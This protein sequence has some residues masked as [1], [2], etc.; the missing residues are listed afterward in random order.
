MSKFINVKIKIPPRQTVRGLQVEDM[1]VDEFDT[2]LDSEREQFC[3]TRCFVC[4]DLHHPH[5]KPYWRWLANGH[6]ICDPCLAVVRHRR[7]SDPW[8]EVLDGM[9]GL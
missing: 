5:T 1:Y 3:L 8:Y 4:A 9:G 2:I 7:E 6:P